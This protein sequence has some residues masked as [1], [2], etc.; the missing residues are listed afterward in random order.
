VLLDVLR[1]VSHLSR[2]T[3]QK[4]KMWHTSTTGSGIRYLTL[5]SFF[6]NSRTLVE[7]MSF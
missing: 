7:L 4:K 1:K 5:R 6:R 3:T 2:G